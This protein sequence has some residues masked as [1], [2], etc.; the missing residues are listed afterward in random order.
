MYAFRRDPALIVSLLATAVRLIAAF[1]IDLSVEQQSAINAVIAGVAG[2][3]IAFLVRDGQAA[4]ILGVAQA[5][6]A[7]AVGFG[8]RLDPDQQAVIMSFVGTAV[9]MFVRTQVTAPAPP[10]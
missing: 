5:L 4:G 9:A 8:L 10:R 2:L 7:L 6:I 1:W 3:W